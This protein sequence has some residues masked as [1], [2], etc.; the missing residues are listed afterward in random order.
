MRIGMALY[1]LGLVLLTGGV[2]LVIAF[3]I[4]AGGPLP[5]SESFFWA[6]YLAAIVGLLAA[7]AILVSQGRAVLGRTGGPPLA[8][9]DADEPREA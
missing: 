2:E 4:R 7:G 5:P 9:S 3:V 1:V 6:A 8:S